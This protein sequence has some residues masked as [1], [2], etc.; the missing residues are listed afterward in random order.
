MQAQDGVYQ[1]KPRRARISTTLDYGSGHPVL[2]SFIV[3][4]PL[5]CLVLA[6]FGPHKGQPWEGPWW[7]PAHTDHS[8]PKS[9]SSYSSRS[10]TR[11][12]E[13]GCSF[14]LTW[15]HSLTLTPAKTK[16]HQLPD[17]AFGGINRGNIKHPS[18]APCPWSQGRNTES[19]QK[20]AS[21]HRRKTSLPLPSSSNAAERLDL[22]LINPVLETDYLSADSAV[23]ASLHLMQK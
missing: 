22:L 2:I 4:F 15:R 9:Q 13:V 17:T 1:R 16:H 18:L 5:S 14:S 23:S 19:E 21:E 3:S 6:A 8:S 20:A 7:W 12:W 11:V 10:Q